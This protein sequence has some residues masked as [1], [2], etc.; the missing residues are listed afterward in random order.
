MNEMSA[1]AAVC[2]DS[3]DTLLLGWGELSAYR[4]TL[5][6]SQTLL[7]DRIASYEVPDYIW[8][9]TSSDRANF[10]ELAVLDDGS[11][12]PFWNSLVDLSP[13]L[14]AEGLCT[15]VEVTGAK[16]GDYLKLLPIE[17]PGCTGANSSQVSHGQ[18]PG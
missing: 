8:G 18:Y 1:I 15:D 16:Y 5:N 7:K 6:N 13:G 17:T 11:C 2:Q 14:T 9:C 3:E 4:F 12:A 10:N